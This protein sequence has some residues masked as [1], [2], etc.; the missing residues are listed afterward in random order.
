MGP[1]I[2]FLDAGRTLLYPARPVGETYAQAGRRHGA[3]HPPDRLEAAFREAFLGKRGE[4]TAQDREW[5]R[6]VVRR[7]FAAL[8][9]DG[10]LEPLFEELYAHFSSPEAWR[11]YPGAAETIRELHRRGYRTGLISNWDDRLP[12][13][14]RG[15]GLLGLLDPRVVSG[16]IGAEKPDPRI[17]LAALEEAGVPAER[18]LMV[19]DDPEADGR[20][21]RDVGMR[22]L[23]IDH[24]GE[25]GPGV[26]ASFS[27]LLERLPPREDAR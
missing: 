16:R 19:G 13:L 12:G 26:V 1:D 7:T 27:G 5:W 2:I 24:G 23:L 17:F 4:G 11:L 18:A 20:G 8:G 15:F 14:L 6:D 22:A 10:D 25:E 21:A 9:T 3:D